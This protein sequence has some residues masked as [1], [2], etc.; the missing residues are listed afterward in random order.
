MKRIW[1]ALNYSLSGLKAVFKE[2]AAFRQEVVLSCILIPAIFLLPMPAIFRLALVFAN[3]LVLITE[4]F[5]S[6]VEAVV[7]KASP[8]IHPLAKAAKDFGSA[9]VLL[10][11]VNLAIC[12]LFALLEV[13]KMF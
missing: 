4:L 8:E 5:N 13:K 10:S 3:M 2:E 6:A 1:N 7:D 9:A 12:W 11:L